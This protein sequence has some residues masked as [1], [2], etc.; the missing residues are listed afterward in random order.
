MHIVAL[1]LLVLVGYS[2]G[3]TIGARGRV[4]SPSLIDL[5]LIVVVWIVALIL[6]P[7]LGKW[8]S[9][10]IWMLA[11]GVIAWGW[12]RARR[13]TLP[14]DKTVVPLQEGKWINRLWHGWTA[15]ARRMG[16][17]QGRVLLA[18]FYFVF[19]TPFALPLR[20]FGD[21]LH[22]KSRKISSFWLDRPQPEADFDQLRSQF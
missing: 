5:G 18:F 17:F 20:L 8:L 1:I 9:I 11:A 3:A 22:I 19:V 7:L 13:N 14:V 6:Q 15:F 21:P 12:T 16:N 4:A 10:L 2:S